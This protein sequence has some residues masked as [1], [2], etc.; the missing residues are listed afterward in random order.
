MARITI[1]AARVTKG[2]TQQEMADKMGISRIL[3][4]NM[5]NGKAE[6]KLP[7]LLAICYLTGFTPD[8]FILPDEST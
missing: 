7:Y 3:L 8:D 4:N 1:A 5:E 6:V 2:W